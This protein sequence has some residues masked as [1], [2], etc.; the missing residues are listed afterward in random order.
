MLIQWLRE[1]VTD[2]TRSEVDE[3]EPLSQMLFNS[4]S[5]VVLSCLEEEEAM[6]ADL[7]SVVNPE[8]GIVSRKTRIRPVGTLYRQRQEDSEPEYVTRFEVERY[9]HSV[10]REN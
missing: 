7:V 5:P 4:H 10:D 6:F 8:A 3:T 9:L 1:G 2:T